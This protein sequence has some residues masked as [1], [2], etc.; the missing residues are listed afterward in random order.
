MQSAI[1]QILSDR[2]RQKSLAVTVGLVT[3]L[4]DFAIVRFHFDSMNRGALAILAMALLVGLTDG[5]RISLGLSLTPRQG[6]SPWIRTSAVLS[7]AVAMCMVIGIGALHLA[8][9]QVPLYTT[10]PDRFLERLLDMCF[11]YP[12]LE[13]TIYRAVV[14]VPLVP[15]IGCW[16]TIIFCGILFGALHVAYGN[17]GPENLVGGFFLAWAYVKSDTI[18]IPILLHAGGNLVVL[19]LQIAGWYL[20]GSATG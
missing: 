8:G 2:P 12:V 13:E 20:L 10:A 16:R 17:P 18:L 5:D 7:V 11:V 4:L 1:G 19:L 6:W 3:I 14:C 9:R 15:V